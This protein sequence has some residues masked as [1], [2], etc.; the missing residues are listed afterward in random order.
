MTCS[1]FDVPCHLLNG[2]SGA[3]SWIPWWAQVGVVIGVILIIGGAIL[4]FGKIVKVIAGWPGVAG[5]GVIVVAIV[6]AIAVGLSAVGRKQE[7]HENLK[8]G[9]ADAKPPHQ[10]PK[11]SVP[12][13]KPKRTFNTDTNTWE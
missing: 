12:R 5:V 1:L 11:V 3:W 7:P 10:K 13:R 8:P 4:N 9:S 2:I 6:G